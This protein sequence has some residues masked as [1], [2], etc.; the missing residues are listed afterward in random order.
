MV[1]ARAEQETARGFDSLRL[2]HPLFRESIESARGVDHRL[3]EGWTGE[4]S[5]SGIGVATCAQNESK[6][7]RSSA[8][9]AVIT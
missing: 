9:A 7:R 4:N 1:V 3:E 2:G 5:S 8:E 6:P